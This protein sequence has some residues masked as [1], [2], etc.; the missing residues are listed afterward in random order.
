MN[1]L[2]TIAAALMLLTT[3][4][5]LFAGG[6]EIMGPILSSDLPASVRAVAEVVW[7]GIS[8]ILF[9][10]ALGLAWLARVPNQPLLAFILAVQVGFAALFIGLGLLRL[11]NLS[12]MPQWG[13][14]L[15]VP[16]TAWLG[17]RRWP[18][19]PTNGA[20]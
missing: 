5:H 17:A 15:L 10:M 13:I 3:G 12:V 4:V 8:L 2:L 9:L 18:A 19:N 16:M 14:F 6:P 1:V 20:R 11:G 7:H